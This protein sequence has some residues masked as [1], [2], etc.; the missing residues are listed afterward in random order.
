MSQTCVRPLSIGRIK[1]CGGL[2]PFTVSF[3][4]GCHMH[5]YRVP[6][7]FSDSFQLCKCARLSTTDNGRRSTVTNQLLGRWVSVSVCTLS[8]PLFLQLYF[9]L[10]QCA[11]C[12]CNDASD[13]ENCVC[14]LLN[15]PSVSIYTTFVRACVYKAH[16]AQASMHLYELIRVRH[17]QFDGLLV[18]AASVL[19]P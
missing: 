14:A 6:L 13:V 10:C 11:R 1:L 4:C 15:F 16:C 18:C 7:A 9:H 3:W 19:Q 8:L 17:R 12:V 5:E 2:R